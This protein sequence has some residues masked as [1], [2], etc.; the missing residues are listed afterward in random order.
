MDQEALFK[1][2]SPGG[3]PR[4][5]QCYLCKAWTL[6][7]NLKPIEVPDQT[8]YV[9][10]LACRTCLDKIIGGSNASLEE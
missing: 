9:K 7:M 8:G 4:L 5:N 6:E 3:V 2:D 10:K 1:Q